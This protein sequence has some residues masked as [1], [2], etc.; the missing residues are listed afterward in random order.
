[1]TNVEKRE[2]EL[3]EN[4]QRKD[5]T[6]YE[7]SK[8]IVS[9]AETAAELDTCTDSVQLGP[10]QQPGSLR[11]VSER[12]GIPPMTI[13]DAQQHVTAIEEFP[14]LVD[15]PQ[16]R[17]ID[18]ARSLRSGELTVGDLGDDI[19]PPPEEPADERAYRLFATQ[20]IGAMRY[21]AVRMAAIERDDL[22]A[23]V[24]FLRER[25]Q[26]AE[27]ERAELRRMLNLEQQNVARLLP[28]AVPTAPPARER[29]KR[30]RNHRTLLLCPLSAKFGLSRGG[31]GCSDWSSE[32]QA[33]TGGGLGLMILH[34]YRHSG[35]AKNRGRE[36]AS[37]R[38]V[39]TTGAQ[40]WKNKPALLNGRGVTW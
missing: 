15:Y 10:R 1:M 24:A 3:E 21:S 12:I 29:V 37:V 30:P 17:A 28:A 5:L 19:P 40:V 4:L 34:I 22:R 20:A 18:T 26:E 16:S 11:R 35:M 8:T 27:R 7:R 32:C 2:M 31:V 23:E 9:L 13:N 38:D 39:T 6:A 14:G 36:P 33:R 25:L